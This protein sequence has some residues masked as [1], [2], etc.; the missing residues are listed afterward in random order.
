MKPLKRRSII[1]Q[2]ADLLRDSLEKGTLSGR[3]PGV[4]K[5]AEEA[6]VS[7]LTMRAALRILEDEGLVELS[8]NGYSRYSVNRKAPQ[9]KTI[10]IGIL[11]PEPLSEQIAQFQ[12]LIIEVQHHLESLG[13]ESFIFKEDLRQLKHDVSRV[14]GMLA[15]NPVNACLVV[16]GSREVLEWFADQSLPCLAIFGRAGG[17]PISRVGPSKSVAILEGVRKLIEYGHRR[18]VFL[19]RVERRVPQLGSFERM[20]LAELESNGI[21][22]S[23][24]NIPD[25]EE[26]PEGFHRLL[27]ELFRVT[28]PTA[29]I[30]DEVP[31]WVGTQQF[32]AKHGILVPEQVSLMATDDDPAFYWFS[33]PVAHV[34]WQNEPIIKRIGRWSM[35]VKRG[36]VEIKC[37]TDPAEF[38][39]GGTI[40]PVPR[41]TV[42]F[43]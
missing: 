37:D 10:R 21:E 6:G 42:K 19:T 36:N 12:Q 25:W 18:I 23:S 14:K 40:G 15:K 35:G 43:K 38:V 2:S 5:L 11:M 28:P 32:L 30:M 8:E 13:F 4:V 20:F 39:L 27:G 29:L 3:L 16:A 24:Y 41:A 33:P 1:E 34:R 26:T 9:K 17:L 7:K 31:M 22:T